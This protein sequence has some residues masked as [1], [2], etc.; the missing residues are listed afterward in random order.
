MAG[1][2]EA[3][4]VAEIHVN[5]SPMTDTTKDRMARVALP[6]DSANPTLFEVRRGDM[7]ARRDALVAVPIKNCNSALVGMVRPSSTMAF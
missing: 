4:C 7:A 5:N 3:S 1:P 6:H 2:G